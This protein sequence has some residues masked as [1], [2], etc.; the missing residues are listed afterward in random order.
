LA[1]LKEGKKTGV[2]YNSNQT[3]FT[4]D[5][6]FEEVVAAVGPGMSWTGC[7]LSSFTFIRFR[8]TISSVN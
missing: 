7:P 6:A 2:I 3:S 5:P 4:W 8:G 1:L